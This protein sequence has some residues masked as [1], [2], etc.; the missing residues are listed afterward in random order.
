[1]T[2]PSRNLGAMMKK[3]LLCGAA[4][5]AIT[6]VLAG[7]VA[8]ADLRQA[9]KAPPP[10]LPPACVWCGFYVGGH[11]GYGQ[12]KFSTTPHEGELGDGVASSKPKGL[13]GGMHA[14]Y[15]WQMNTF[16]F[17]L[18]TDLSATGWSQTVL[19]PNENERAVSTKVNLLG[20]LRGRLGLSFDRTL[21]YITGG[22]AYTQ[23]K[24][25]GVSPGGTLTLGKFSKWGTVFG[26]GAEWMASRNFSVRLEG[27]WYNFDSSKPIYGAA[28]V[29]RESEAAG[30]HKFK[31][32]F[33]VRFGATHHFN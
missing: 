27:L 14:G 2:S 26:G 1:M 23:G 21:L 17:G 22:L 16:V 30:A 25:L 33:V 13:V 29:D 5:I 19:F 28:N 10:A 32:A 11:L 3:Q 24:F 8:A 15:N 6:T 4:A 31:D 12:A 18:E 20:S 7:P 9:Y